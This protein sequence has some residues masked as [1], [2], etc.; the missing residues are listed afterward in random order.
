MLDIIGSLEGSLQLHLPHLQLVHKSGKLCFISSFTTLQIHS[1]LVPALFLLFAFFPFFEK[2]VFVSLQ[3]QCPVAMLCTLST[4]KSNQSG[5]CWFGP[6]KG[7]CP[8]ANLYSSSVLFHLG[9]VPQQGHRCLCTTAGLL[10]FL[11]I[12]A[13]V[14]ELWGSESF[15]DSAWVGKARNPPWVLKIPQFN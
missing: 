10:I 6:Q 3:F 5:G 7:F 12:N 11:L 15:S 2:Q 9:P 13:T 4:R 14:A 8:A 1:S